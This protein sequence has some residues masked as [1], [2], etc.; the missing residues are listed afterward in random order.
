MSEREKESSRRGAQLVAF[1]TSTLAE[2]SVRTQMWRQ[3][4]C[5]KKYI[6]CEGR[7]QVSLS[8]VCSPQNCAHS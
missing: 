8:L 5:D 4:A 1:N 7:E 6:A 2:K 3:P